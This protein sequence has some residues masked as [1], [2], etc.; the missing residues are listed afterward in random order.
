M[1]TAPPWIR[2]PPQPGAT[3]PP[4]SSP[5]A[6]TRPGT[7]TPW[8]S[9]PG[10]DGLS[11]P[12][13]VAAS[14]SS[15]PTPRAPSTAGRCPDQHGHG[16]EGERQHP[17]R[18]PRSLPGGRWP[19]KPLLPSSNHP[20]RPSGAAREPPDQP[21]RSP[22]KAAFCS[23]RGGWKPH[24]V[25]RAGRLSSRPLCH[26]PARSAGQGRRAF[27]PGPQ[28]RAATR[29]PGFGPSMASMA[30]THP[31]PATSTGA[32]RPCQ[33]AT[34]FS[35]GQAAF[36]HLSTLVHSANFKTYNFITSGSFFSFL[37]NSL[38]RSVVTKRAGCCD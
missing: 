25:E 28:P 3:H 34:G 32:P 5:S 31:L 8:P 37:F 17:V 22:L 33:R 21:A 35:T 10:Q 7:C 16:Q 29:R 6:S 36:G 24:L 12:S 9:A 15:G 4:A 13:R 18:P 38:S 30:R 2:T 1:A 19:L 20:S 23:T 26:V 11:R 14:A 27:A